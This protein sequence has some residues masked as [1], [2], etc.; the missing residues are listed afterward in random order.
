[1]IEFDGVRQQWLSTDSGGATHDIT[2]PFYQAKK[3]KY[4][5]RDRLE[6]LLGRP[7]SV[8]RLHHAVVFPGSDRPTEWITPE[9][10]PGI[11]IGRQD[12]SDLL[13]RINDILAHSQGNAPFPHGPEIVNGL[14]RLLARTTKLPNPLRS[15][16]DAE[17]AE[18]QTL[19]NSQI[20]LFR[21]LQ[22]TRRLSIGGGAGSG[23][24]YVAV[25]R[26]RELARQGFPTLLVCYGEPL[27]QFLKSLVG[28]E[29][30]LEAMTLVN[31]PVGMYLN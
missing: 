21:R 19:T 14:L 7:A 23:K 28:T 11:I 3:G 16:I 12:L 6:E 18:I 30:N 26:A 13:A 15:Q 24:T 9:A 5:L 1:M 2:N 27:A 4:N 31:W 20:D 22:G 17:H 8:I 29:P 25:Q 10:D